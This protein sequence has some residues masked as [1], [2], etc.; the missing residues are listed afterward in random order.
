MKKID[1]L[2]LFFTLSLCCYAQE[3]FNTGGDNEITPVYSSLSLPLFGFGKS[4]GVQRNLFGFPIMSSSFSNNSTVWKSA[5]FNISKYADYTNE[6]FFDTD[7]GPVLLCV[8]GVV[9]LITGPIM[10]ATSGGGD[11]SG[12]LTGGIIVFSLGFSFITGE[13][14]WLT[15]R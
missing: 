4:L 7:I 2:L 13:I 3:S 11:N 10:M 8:L 14:L 1:L 12:L 9:S 5:N 15:L 6:N